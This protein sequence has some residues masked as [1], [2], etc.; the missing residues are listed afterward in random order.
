MTDRSTFLDALQGWLALIAFGVLCLPEPWSLIAGSPDMVAPGSALTALLALPALGVALVRA[1]SGGA[2][3]VPIGL[4]LLFVPLALAGAGVEDARDTFGAS[5]ALLMWVGGAAFLVVGGTLGERGR[6]VLVGGLPV[7]TIG[8]LVSTLTVGGPVAGAFEPAGVLGNTGDLSEAALCGAVLG[9]GAFLDRR[10]A[11]GLSGL[12]AL[13]LYAAHAGYVPVYAGL[14]GLGAAAATSLAGFLLHRSGGGGPAAARRARLFLVALFV[15]AATTGIASLATSAGDE[16]AAPGATATAPPLGGGGA[17]FRLATWGTIPAVMADAGA[18]GLG[19]GQFAATYPPYRSAEEIEISTFRRA[20]PTPVDVEHA[21]NDALTA[22]A[23]YGW[24]G[25]SAFALLL[26]LVLVRAVA[27]AAGNDGSRRDF[28]LAAIAVVAVSLVNSPLLYGPAAPMA[29]FTVFGVVLATGRPEG[30]RPVVEVLAVA[31]PL[32][33]VLLTARASLDF[34]THGAEFAAVRDAYVRLEDG[35]EQL[36][37]ERLG[38]ALDGALLARGDSPMALEKLTQLLGRRLDAATSEAERR[39]LTEARREAL[40]R[41]LAV[42]PESVAARINAGVFEARA[43]RPREAARHLDAALA[44]DAGNPL[45]LRNRLSLAIDL[46]DPER[47]RA[48]LAALEPLGEPSLPDLERRARLALLGG[49][50][51]TADALV[52]SLRRRTSREEIDVTDLNEVT[53]EQARARTAGDDGMFDAYL[54]ASKVLLAREQLASESASQAA[55]SVRSVL[56]RLPAS[57]VDDGALRL[58]LAAAY[59]AAGDVDRARSTLE[60]GP[61]SPTDVDRLGEGP[62]SHLRDA[63][64]LD[65]PSIEAR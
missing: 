62:R 17:A 30:G 54:T 12:V 32:A 64:L 4:P 58:L 15:G 1:I 21:H 39:S 42:R 13:V 53:R 60:E 5:R 28:A 59:A 35:R 36:D 56:Q 19:P 6:R 48:A 65:R 51:E 20:E 26:L 22:F 40:A 24:V 57:E 63:G 61:L 8:L 49:R 52:R 46:R 9:A 7:V 27:Q 45:L 11:L 18:T 34:V 10:G 37:G 33:G 2:F 50:L 23:E 31:V 47:I 43:G 41:L 29:A 3:G 14:L 16:G 55:I 44:L 25:G 38:R